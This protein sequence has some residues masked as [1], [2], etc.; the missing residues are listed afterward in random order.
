[1]NGEIICV[2]TEL[3]LG[4]I[5]NTNAQYL[6]RELAAMGI[7]VFDQVT[8][9]DNAARLKK[10]LGTAVARSQVVIIT[11]GLGPTKDD[12]T[13]ET[14]AEAVGLPLEEDEESLRRIEAYFQRVGRPMGESNRKQA[15]KPRGALV[16]PNDRGTAPGYA[17]SAGNQCI[18]LLPG[19]P[20]EMKPMFENYVKPYLARYGTGTIVSHTLRVFGI[21]ESAAAER[22]SDLLDGSNPTVA[23]YAKTG[24]VELRVTASAPTRVEADAMCQ[25]VISE[26]R[27][28]LE[29]RLALFGSDGIFY[30]LT[31]DREHEPHSLDETR[32][33][34]KSFLYR[35]RRWSGKREIDYIYLIEGRHG[36]HRYHIHAVLRDSDF[37]PAVVRYLWPYGIDVD[38]QPLL[39][40]E[41]DS[42]S[43]LA[44]Y[45]NKERSDGVI[46]PLDKKLWVV[47]Q[48]LRRQLPPLEKWRDESGII[49]IPPGAVVLQ[50]QPPYRNRFGCYT[51]AKWF[52]P[53]FNERARARANN[54]GIESNK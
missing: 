15:L 27:R 52:S 17:I 22:I 39:K 30:T 1:M 44:E 26:I 35:L 10:A 43:R 34:W 6:S 50:E 18:I 29:L 24:E 47:S 46:I 7:G 31:F 21:G 40:G 19:P 20:D 36:D 53:P 5:V 23:P 45:M 33:K 54:L 2:G 49:E 51:Y 37:P 25:P 8:V 48:S 13:K 12:L 9:G 28:R 3:L 41:M 38:D 16:F 42:Y 32:R 14:V 11:G 4:D